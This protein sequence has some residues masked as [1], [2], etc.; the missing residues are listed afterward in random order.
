MFPKGDC[1]NGGG[2]W[3][4]SNRYWLNDGYGHSVLHD[5]DEVQRDRDYAPTENWGGECLGIY[6]PRLLRDGWQVVEHTDK[7]SV[8]D[9][10]LAHGWQLRKLAHAQIDS[11]AGKGCY[12]DEHQLIHP[13]SQTCVSHPDWEWAEWDRHRLVWTTGGKLFGGILQAEGLTDQLELSD[14]NAWE[15]ERIKAPY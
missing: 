13:A 9:K 11:P 12:W 8:F 15:F 2:L 10:P 1:W 5:T 14:F 3:T 7:Y 4:S 6:Y